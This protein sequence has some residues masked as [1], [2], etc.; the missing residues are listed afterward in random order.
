MYIPNLETPKWF[1]SGQLLNCYQTAPGITDG[2][3]VLFVFI[4]AP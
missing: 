4:Y 1:L 3:Y 2:L